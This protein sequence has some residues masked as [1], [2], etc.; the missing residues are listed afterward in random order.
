[1]LFGSFQK[2]YSKKKYLVLSIFTS[3]IVFIFS[4]YLPNFKLVSQVIHN[5]IYSFLEKFNFLFSLLG[6]IGTN[7]NL[8]SG[9]YTILISLLFGINLAF[10]LYFIE[11]RINQTKG[12]ASTTGFVGLLTGILGIGCAAC[13]SILLTGILSL[14]GASWVIT[15][16]P[17]NGEEFGILGVILLSISIYFLSKKIQNPLVCKI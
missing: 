17:L 13:G 4:V 6:S 16:L 8:L 2:V 5:N 10:I 9:T 15:I 12:N 3:L 14:F 7:F 1:M 11:F